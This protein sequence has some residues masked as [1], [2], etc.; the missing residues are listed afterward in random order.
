MERV[1]RVHSHEL[2]LLVYSRGV[3]LSHDVAGQLQFLNRLLGAH[4]R[5]MRVGD[6]DPKSRFSRN[7]STRQLRIRQLLHANTA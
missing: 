2:K 7:K 6:S 1:D 3:R 5:T 4:G